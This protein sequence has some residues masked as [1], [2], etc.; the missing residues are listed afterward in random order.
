MVKKVIGLLGSPLPEGNT[1]RLL[2]QAMQGA[3]TPAAKWNSFR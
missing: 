3:R 1:A 2:A